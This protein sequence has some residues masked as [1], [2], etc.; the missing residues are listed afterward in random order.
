MLPVLLASLAA[1]APTAG[2][3][4]HIESAE[5]T[6]SQRRAALRQSVVVDG[7]IFWG[8]RRARGM[9]FDADHRTHKAAIRVRS[10]AR[11]TLK[12]AARDRDWLSLDYDRTVRDPPGVPVTRFVPCAPDTPRFS[13]DGVVGQETSW[14]GGFNVGRP[15]CATLLLR[16]AGAAEWR[17]V[18][19]GFGQACRSA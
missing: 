11:L 8:L 14:A 5:P 7:T 16:R 3:D 2:C 18:R 19:V 1:A 4:S 17:R 15:G 10:G 12:V 9:T 6:A 13:D